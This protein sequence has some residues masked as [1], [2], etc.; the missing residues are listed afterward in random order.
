MGNCLK[1]Q[2]KSA[3]QNNDLVRVSEL[4]IP[5]DNSI[6]GYTNPSMGVYNSGTYGLRAT[7]G[8]LYLNPSGDGFTEKD[9][10]TGSL[11]FYIKQSEPMNIFI[12][13]KY[14][15]TRLYLTFDAPKFEIS[16][17][18]YSPN[19]TVLE[20]R[21]VTPFT[22]AELMSVCPSLNNFTLPYRPD[23]LKG[24]LSDF[25]SNMI[26]LFLS[27]STI[28]GD[29]DTLLDFPDLQVVNLVDTPN[30]TKKRST[31]NTLSQLIPDFS[32]SGNIIEDV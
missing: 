16:S 18:K 20:L 25:R 10:L 1:T 7:N 24:N 31:I 17:L 22:V 32:A 5:A 28:L 23:I 2:L 11:T 14:A 30:I 9:N 15:L 26:G 29:L 27:N 3:V 6:A 21:T 19:I 8:L 12:S 13:N 4:L